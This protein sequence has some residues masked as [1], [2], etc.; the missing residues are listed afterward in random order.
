MVFRSFHQGIFLMAS[1]LVV[2]GTARA[3]V[4]QVKIDGLPEMLGPSSPAED[5]Y[6]PVSVKIV[7]DVSSPDA[8]KVSILLNGTL[9]TSPKYVCAM[10]KGKSKVCRCV[11]PIIP[12][13]AGKE[14]TC[15]NGETGVDA[16]ISHG[17]LES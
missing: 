8:S 10:Y 7:D 13:P 3:E 6:T 12:V 11:Y 4:C 9:A 2:I 17:F 15:S 1:L 16:F 14:T 5:V